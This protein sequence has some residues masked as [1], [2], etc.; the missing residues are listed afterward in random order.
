MDDREE[1]VFKLME[2]AQA[3]LAGDIEESTL[4]VAL[5]EDQIELAELIN[6]I[7]SDF[8]LPSVMEKME[9]YNNPCIHVLNE[10]FRLAV[11]DYV[12]EFMSAN[13]MLKK[14]SIRYVP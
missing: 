5:E 6:E 14:V 4:M 3:G 2:M 12:Y 9:A 10:E 7:I 8:I 1:V 11:V 13:D